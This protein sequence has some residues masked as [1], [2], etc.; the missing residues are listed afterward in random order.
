MAALNLIGETMGIDDLPGR[1]SDDLL[2]AVCECL[3][4]ATPASQGQRRRATDR[5]ASADRTAR[6]E[7]EL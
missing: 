7:P 6:R 1:D 4:I 2:H 5:G 3:R